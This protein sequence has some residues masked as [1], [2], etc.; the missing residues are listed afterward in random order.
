V[1]INN[2]T[3]ANALAAKATVVGSVFKGYV[4]TLIKLSTPLIGNTYP[5]IPAFLQVVGP[6]TKIPL[7]KPDSTYNKGVAQFLDAVTP[8]DPRLITTVY[9]PKKDSLWLFNATSK[10]QWQHKLFDYSKYGWKKYIPDSIEVEVAQTAGM[11]N[12]G[13]MSMNFR[14]MRLDDVYLYYAEVMHG[15]GQD[16]A[17]IEYLNKLVRRANGYPVNVASIVD[18]NPT[19]VMAEIRN[20]TYLEL[21][22]E[23]KLWFHFRRWNRGAIE[24]GQFGFQANKNECLPIPQGEFDSNPSLKTQNIGYN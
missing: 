20:Q 13:H 10:P 12:D 6:L 22:L 1:V 4:D 3:L 9:Y 16:G 2:Q 14:L 11:G 15:I 5:N 19:D 18:V 17:A 23:G 7:Y 24:F 8:K 21:C